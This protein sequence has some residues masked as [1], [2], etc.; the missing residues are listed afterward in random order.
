[1]N[2]CQVKRGQKGRMPEGAEVSLHRW[3]LK[4]ALVLVVCYS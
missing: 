3:Q 4:F 1:M 2:A